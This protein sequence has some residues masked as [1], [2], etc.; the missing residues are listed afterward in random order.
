[1]AASRS[2]GVTFSARFDSF[3]W[4]DKSAIDL[5]S[6]KGLPRQSPRMRSIPGACQGPITK[7]RSKIMTDWSSELTTHSGFK[8]FVRTVRPDD[9]AALREFFEH[10]TPEDLRFRSSPASRKSDLSG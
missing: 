2:V 9:E 8:F 3:F 6:V 7:W 4:A 1:M 10:V 5:T